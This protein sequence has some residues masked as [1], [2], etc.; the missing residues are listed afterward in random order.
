MNYKK[1]TPQKHTQHINHQRGPSKESTVVENE[2]KLNISIIDLIPG[3]SKC[4]KC[5]LVGEG[6]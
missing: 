5:P 1:N 4:A 3:S 6:G 2:I